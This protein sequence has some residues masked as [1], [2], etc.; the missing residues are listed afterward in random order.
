MHAACYAV[1]RALVIGSAF[2][3]SGVEARAR[4]LTLCLPLDVHPFIEPFAA[5]MRG[6]AP[7]ASRNRPRHRVKRSVRGLQPEPVMTSHH[8]GSNA[9]DDLKRSRNEGR[10]HPT[11]PAFGILR[12]RVFAAG[13]ARC[14]AHVSRSFLP[15]GIGGLTWR[16]G[17]RPSRPRVGRLGVVALRRKPLLRCSCTGANT[18]VVT[19][20]YRSGGLAHAGTVTGSTY[21]DPH[22]CGTRST[23][24]ASCASS[25]S[26]VADPETE[27][28]Q[29][30]LEPR[31][32]R[33]HV[34]GLST[35]V[36]PREASP[37]GSRIILGLPQ[38][39]P[40]VTAPYLVL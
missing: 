25:A 36:R 10:S 37:W 35:G 22:I 20:P 32:A 34:G 15:V 23:T 5:A 16:P 18:N 4:R 2:V 29:T 6:T 13:G 24:P 33:H 8:V 7:D 40:V 17:G 3:T 1:G 30:G 12:N 21:P 26:P 38:L 28:L 14:A 9:S 19:S 39:T 27:R 11:G 31:A